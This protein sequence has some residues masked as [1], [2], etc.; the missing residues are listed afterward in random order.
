MLLRK[1]PVEETSGAEVGG[2]H[3]VC[4]EDTGSMK[5]RGVEVRVRNTPDTAVWCFVP[6]YRRKEGFTSHS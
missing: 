4:A 1:L 6:L 3:E 5:G 2:P